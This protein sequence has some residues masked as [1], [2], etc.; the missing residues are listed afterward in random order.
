MFWLTSGTLDSSGC[1][2]SL[3]ALRPL[4]VK[5]SR[6]HEWTVQTPKV[7]FS[8]LCLSG[9]DSELWGWYDIH[10]LS[11]MVGLFFF[12]NFF[13][14]FLL[15]MSNK[16]LWSWSRRLPG[17]IKVPRRNVF[18]GKWNPNGD[19]INRRP[20]VNAGMF[21]FSLLSSVC[22]CMR[23]LSTHFFSHKSSVK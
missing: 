1:W 4:G 17:R 20:I 19:R 3:I 16:P 22:V 21:C 9:A 23:Q 2:P 8:C 6:T 5:P 14:L 10:I 7:G 11:S 12:Y 15:L 13:Y 18:A